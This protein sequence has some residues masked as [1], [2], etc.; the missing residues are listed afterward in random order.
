MILLKKFLVF[1]ILVSMLAS[2]SSVYAGMDDDGD[3]CS[4]G[5][6]G[7]SFI[8]IYIFPWLDWHK[9]TF[10]ERQ[11]GGGLPPNK[12]VK[13]PKIISSE[14]KLNREKK[15]CNDRRDCQYLDPGECDDCFKVRKHAATNAGLILLVNATEPHSYVSGRLYGKCMFSSKKQSIQAGCNQKEARNTHDIYFKDILKEMKDYKKY[16]ENNYRERW[17]VNDTKRKTGISTLTLYGGVGYFTADANLGAFLQGQ[18]S[19][20]IKKISQYRYYVAFTR[21]GGGGLL[22]KLQTIIPLSKLEG[23]QFY[24]GEY[25]MSFTF[26]IRT[27]EGRKGLKAAINNRILADMRIKQL[28]KQNDLAKVMNGQQGA[29]LL[30]V[31]SGELGEND[32]AWRRDIEGIVPITSRLNTRKKTTLH[33]QAGVPFLGRGRSSTHKEKLHKRVRVFRN[34][35]VKDVKSK[36]YI[37]QSAWRHINIPFLLPYDKKWSNF[38]STHSHYNT[39]YQGIARHAIFEDDIQSSIEREL[40]MQASY[41]NDNVTAGKFAKKKERIAKK[42][43]LNTIRPELPYASKREI[44][45]AA[46]YYRLRLREEDISNLIA[47]VVENENVLIETADALINRYVSDGVNDFDDPYNL[48][49]GTFTNKELTLSYVKWVTKRKLKAI[50]RWLKQLDKSKIA[51]S[52]SKTS[53]LLAKVSKA[54]GK[55]QFVLQSVLQQVA[56]E[57]NRLGLF[58]LAGEEFRKKTYVADPVNNGAETNERIDEPGALEDVNGQEP[59]VGGKKVDDWLNTYLIEEDF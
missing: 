4:V 8:S 53:T 56:T 25:T 10:L 1:L 16:G 3:D 6:F 2:P 27:K 45:S 32:L 9:G 36:T 28:K 38:P 23:F 18:W 46:A 52:K 34:N 14:E 43:G 57:E 20:K 12:E 55:N 47:K 19:K 22:A 39:M 44:G 41:S 58:T 37:R 13:R 15:S 50:T 42:I 11:S 48:F 30:D 54:M 17:S 33:G 51:A 5:F 26:D 35:A 59:M 40:R 24:N 49:R 7:D 31:A 29:E 21:E